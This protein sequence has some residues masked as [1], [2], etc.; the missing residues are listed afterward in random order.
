MT[1]NPKPR[2]KKGWMNLKVSKIVSET[3]DT[4]TFYLEDADDGGLV[5]DYIAGQYL[6]FRFDTLSEKPIVRSYTMSSSP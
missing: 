5:F 4:K 1:E 2:R 3:H 6:T